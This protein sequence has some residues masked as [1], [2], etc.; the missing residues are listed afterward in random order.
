MFI[1]V[2]GFVNFVEWPVIL[3]R[4][5]HQLL[6]V[7]ILARTLILILLALELYQVFSRTND[8]I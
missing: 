3:S 1:I 7:T 6:L 4:G 2:L 8:P 5:M